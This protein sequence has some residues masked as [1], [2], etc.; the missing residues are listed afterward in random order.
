MSHCWLCSFPTWEACKYFI[1]KSS[2]KHLN[3]LDLTFEKGRKSYC[4]FIKSVLLLKGQRGRSN[5][6]MREI[7]EAAAS[8]W[9][10]LR[11]SASQSAE[12]SRIRHLSSISP[13][14]LTST[15]LLRLPWLSRSPPP[16]PLPQA[17][18]T[19]YEME[20]IRWQPFR[21]YLLWRT[22]RKKKV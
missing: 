22:L 19:R 10:Q 7:T 14:R 2:M 16:Q 5:L 9:I 17:A 12:H 11:P 8:S 13:R 18:G 15:Q 4:S 6:D 3:K 1:L 20:R 21:S